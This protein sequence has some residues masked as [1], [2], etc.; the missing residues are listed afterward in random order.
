MQARIRQF[1]LACGFDRECH[2]V[3]E[4]QGPDEQSRALI[5]EF[6]LLMREGGASVD[7]GTMKT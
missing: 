6:T 4:G 7:R 3:R 2:E 5:V 1:C